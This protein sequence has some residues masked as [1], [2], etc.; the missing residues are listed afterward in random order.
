MRGPGEGS[1]TPPA[2]RPYPRPPVLFAGA[3]AV[4]GVGPRH[5]IGGRGEDAI[6]GVPHRRVLPLH[7]VLRGGPE[8][9]TARAFRSDDR[10]HEASAGSRPP[11]RRRA[12]AS[13]PPTSTT[14]TSRASTTPSPTRA[15]GFAGHARR[16]GCAARSSR[17]AACSRSTWG[18]SPTSRPRRSGTPWAMG[19]SGGPGARAASS[20]GGCAF[21][22]PQDL[23]L[24]APRLDTRGWG[25]P[26]DLAL[27]VF[28]LDRE[29][30]TGR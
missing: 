8:P 14:A 12:T 7:V 4:A 28:A 23:R 11:R 10:R 25:D 1:L 27:P 16:P 29:P 22:R 24:R 6:L 13:S 26:R 2:R 17:A 21:P 3:R 15:C 20:A 9:G 18:A 19:A 5:R 30:S